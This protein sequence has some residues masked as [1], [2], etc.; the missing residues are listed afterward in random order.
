M[1]GIM[2]VWVDEHRSGLRKALILLI[3]VTCFGPWAFDRINVPA[4][5]ECTPPNIRLYGDFCGMPFSGIRFILWNAGA[6][7]SISTGLL[8]GEFALSDRIREL[9][10]SLL[11]LLPL[12]PVFGTLLLVFR[13]DLVRRQLF[14]VIAW[15]LAIGVCLFMSLTIEP[16]QLLASWGL[17]LYTGLAL[18]AL[19]LEIIVIRE[20]NS[21]SE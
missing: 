10:I 3:V 14:T 7:I 13:G 16:K 20:R 11:L 18:C 8:A 4:E 6:F 15:I 1:D 9:W 19:I 2:I 5:Y 21:V 17:W 12:L